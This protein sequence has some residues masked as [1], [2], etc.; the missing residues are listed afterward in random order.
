[1]CVYP[2]LPTGRRVAE[3]EL[4][5]ALAQ[6]I[7]NFRVEYRDEKPMD[8]IQT[9]FLVPERRLDLAFVDL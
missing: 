2:C 8:Y 9:L 7:K 4:H 6:L 3:L 5:I 1:M